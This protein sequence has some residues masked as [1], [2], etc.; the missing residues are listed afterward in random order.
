M[1]VLLLTP[2]IKCKCVQTATVQTEKHGHSFIPLKCERLDITRAK[3]MF[4]FFGKL[5]EPTL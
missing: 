4:G 3:C 2:Y 1:T 5:H